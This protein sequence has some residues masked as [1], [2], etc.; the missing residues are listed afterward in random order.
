MKKFVI[1]LL[2]ATPLTSN[3]QK[4]ALLDI[5]YKKPVLFTDSV[6]ISQLAQGYFPV[7]V[8]KI[9]SFIANLKY[10]RDRVNPKVNVHRSKTNSFRLK[11]GSTYIKVETV[12][13]AYG[14]SYNVYLQSSVSG[15]SADYLL[16]SHEMLTKG[17][18]KRI[19][20]FIKYLKKDK[21]LTINEYQE[22]SPTEIDQIIYIK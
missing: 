9:D 21:S 1:A 7:E 13:H 2:F 14:D 8:S 19:N 16:A 10:V 18:A 6:S 15:I 22:Y 11:A 17:I 5:D 4:V 20:A 12:P 3:A